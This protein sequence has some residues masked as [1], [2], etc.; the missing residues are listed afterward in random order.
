MNHAR[1]STLAAAALLSIVTLTT[2]AC[3]INIGAGGSSDG[4]SWGWGPGGMMHDADESDSRLNMS[5]LMFVQMMIPHHQQAIEMAEL[6]P[7]NAA[8]PAVQQLAS[9]I[10]AAQGPEIEQMQAMLDRWNVPE[11]GDH[12]GHAMP[13]M[14]AEADIAELRDARGAEFD[15]RFLELMI[16]H[17][18]GAIDMA[19]DPLE[20]G[21]DPELRRLLESI[22][23]TQTA[24]IAQMRQL[25][26]AS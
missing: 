21:A 4:T 15:R 5:D 13:G 1:T 10:A 24:E 11:M 3:T 2:T 17:H 19:R 7:T 6:A 12:S 18:E 22:V 20:H 25:L 8:S 26:A 14:V 23:A 16:A 9:T